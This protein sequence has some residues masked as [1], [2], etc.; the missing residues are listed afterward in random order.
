[1]D[2]CDEVEE[3]EDTGCPLSAISHSWRSDCQLIP[4]EVPAGMKLIMVGMGR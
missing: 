1:M 4:S 3:S 2:G